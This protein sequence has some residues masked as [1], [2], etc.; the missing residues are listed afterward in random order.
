M[1]V[2]VPRVFKKFDALT[3]YPFIFIRPSQRHNIGL[4][5]HEMV[6]Y[7]EQKAAWVVPWLVK[8]LFSKEF[9]IAAEERA[10]AVQLE[11]GALSKEDVAYYL[12]L[13]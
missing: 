2:Q 5:A 6:H 1:I 12:S 11:M 7:N 3:V 10:Y 4:L 13:Y 9:R 8:Y